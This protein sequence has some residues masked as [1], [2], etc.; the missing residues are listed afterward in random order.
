MH[1]T[2]RR[3]GKKHTRLIRPT[4]TVIQ[5]AAPTESR[6]RSCTISDYDAIT[7]AVNISTRTLRAVETSDRRVLSSRGGGGT[8]PL[9]A[10]AAV[11]LIPACRL[12]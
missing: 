10:V 8:V 11:P 4:S 12:Q 5:M 3:L 2:L 1:S 9:T 6:L 7:A